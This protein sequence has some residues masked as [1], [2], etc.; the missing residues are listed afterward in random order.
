VRLRDFGFTPPENSYSDSS[1]WLKEHASERLLKALGPAEI[2]EIWDP[3]TGTLEV[4][5]P[6]CRELTPGVINSEAEAYY[7]YGACALLAI[8]L[9]RQ[10]GMP[11]V[12]LVSD[13]QD[14]PVDQERVWVHGCVRTP[15]GDYLDIHGVEDAEEKLA[16]WRSRY[17]D[18]KML[19]VADE[20]EFC[21]HVGDDF[22]SFM[23]HELAV[24][25]DFARLLLHDYAYVLEVDE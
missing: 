14:D 19:E 13:L 23:E 21:S 6:N 10:T 3:E 22:D 15:S 25:E 12:L 24:T 7:S 8:D 4:F 20:A 17:P 2:E 18:I 9:H 16:R 1:R 11:L 5:N